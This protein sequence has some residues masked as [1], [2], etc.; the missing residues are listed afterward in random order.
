MGNLLETT[1]KRKNLLNLFYL[2]FIIAIVVIAL[3]SYSIVSGILHAPYGSG[4]PR[5]TIVPQPSSLQIYSNH[6]LV[7][8]LIEIK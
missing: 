2:S 8:N 3:F 5:P 6:V 1:K 7:F 4:N